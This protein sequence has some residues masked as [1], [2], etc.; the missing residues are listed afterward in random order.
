MSAKEGYLLAIDVG[1]TTTRCMLFDLSGTPIGEAYREPR[2]YH[3]QTN[4]TEVEPEDW[5]DATTA[6]IREV[7]Q[8]AQVPKGKILG[9]GLCGLKHALVPIDASGRPLARAMLWMDQRCQPQAEWL[10]REHGEVIDQIVG[11]GGAMGTTPSAPKLRWIVENEPDLLWQTDK[12]LLVK[13][14]IRFRLTGTVATDPSDAGGT[15][16]YD[17]RSGGWSEPLLDLI[18]VP[19]EKMP[20]ILVSTALAGRV[21]KA[22]AEVTGLAPGTPVVVGA[23]DVRCTLIGANAFGSG[24]ETPPGGRAE[25]AR[26]CLYLGTAAWL[27]IARRASDKG[28]VAASHPKPPYRSLSADCL[29]ATATTGAALKWLM[30]LFDGQRPGSLLPSYADLFREAEGSPLG[31]RGLIFLPHLMGERAPR[32]DPQAKGTLFGLTLAHTRGDFARAVLEGCAFQLRRIADRLC[33]SGMGEVVV[34]GGG[35]KN[36]LWLGIIADVMGSALL[37]PRV[38]EAGALGAAILAGVGV[39]VYAGVQAAAQELVQMAG[40]IE[41]GEVRHERYGR[42][43][44]IFLELEDRVAP[45][46]SRLPVVQF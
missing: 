30:T 19:L 11:G 28:P 40:R 14:F 15:C 5:W 35:A 37:V 18:G 23:G 20:P 4:W 16:L 31:A 26:A 36:P 7:L 12:F 13:D 9:V 38:L 24:E 46:Y 27:S 3:P 1:T 34:V 22:A 41:P 29:G 10:T 44:S 39:G 17:A 25:W 45:L 32:S 42:I 6:V 33:P 21:T 2:V 8:R 43:Y